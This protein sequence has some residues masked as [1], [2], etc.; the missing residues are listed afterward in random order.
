MSVIAQ[1]EPAVVE[2]DGLQPSISEKRMVERVARTAAAAAP[3]LVDSSAWVAAARRG[4]AEMPA[5]VRHSLHAFRRDSGMQGVLLVR[6]LPVDEHLL[7]RTPAAANSAQRSATLPAALLMSFACGLGDPVAYA[8]EKAGALVQD[9]VP[10]PGREEFQGNA[11]SV[12]LSFHTENAF[13]SHRPDFVLLL[14]LRTDHDGL[15]GLR[16]ACVRGVL[17]LLSGQ[18]RDVLTSPE[19]VTPPPPSFGGGAGG[20]PLPV[21]SGADG[22]PDLRVDLAATAPLGRKGANALAELAEL[23]ERT[24][25]TVRLWPG[26]MAIVDNRVAV[27]GRTSFKPRYD[28]G[29]RWLQRTF[30]AADLRRSRAWRASD[31]YVLT[32]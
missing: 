32:D 28:G 21:L 24:A 12:A 4:W 3:R 1:M 13:H 18:A 26:D 2:F 17:P 5:A 19:F 16:T 14:C 9:V 30:V 29:D 23:F 8:A 11:G 10:V 25:R 27:H 7:P 20:A 22:D 6:G 15:A 31:G